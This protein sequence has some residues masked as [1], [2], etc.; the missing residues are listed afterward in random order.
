MHSKKEV[1]KKEFK[2][3]ISKQLRSS[4][5][6]TGFQNSTKVINSGLQ[7]PRLAE[8]DTHTKEK[9]EKKL[10]SGLQGPR[11]AGGRNNSE[12]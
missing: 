10:H 1:Q 3:M 4:G 12:F 2:K 8:N 7:G 5:T 11:L 9:I 6:S